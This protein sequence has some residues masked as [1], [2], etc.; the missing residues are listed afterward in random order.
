MCGKIVPNWMCEYTI[1]M[2]GFVPQNSLFICDFNL[3]FTYALTGWEESAIDA[4]IYEEACSDDL[5][6]PP[7]KYLLA[8]AG[9]PLYDRLFSSSEILYL[10]NLILTHNHSPLHQ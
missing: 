9:F 1:L 8:N 2:K 10:T 3:Q 5:I 7:S 6:I 4:H